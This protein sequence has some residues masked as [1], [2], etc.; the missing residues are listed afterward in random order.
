VIAIPAV[1]TIAVVTIAVVT[2]A[3][4]TIAVVTIAVVHRM[5]AAV[6]RVVDLQIVGERISFTNLV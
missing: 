2:I 3:V 5:M 1:V 6:H 4:V